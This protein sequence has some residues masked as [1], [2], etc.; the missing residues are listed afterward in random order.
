VADK[1]LGR[2]QSNGVWPKFTESF[3]GVVLNR[4]DLNEIE[5]AEAAA[6]TAYAAGGQDVI[7]A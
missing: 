7:G 4:N 5:H 6:N 1:S 3:T 2:C